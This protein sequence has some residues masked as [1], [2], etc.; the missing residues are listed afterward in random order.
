M[1]VGGIGM[2]A[3]NKLTASNIRVYLARHETV[4]ETLEAFKA[5]SLRLVEPEMACAHHGHQH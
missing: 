3:L 1:L 5:G 2:G 4:A